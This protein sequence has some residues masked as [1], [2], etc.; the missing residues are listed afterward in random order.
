MNI[1]KEQTGAQTATLRIEIGPDD[2]AAN[3]QK[4]LKDYQKKASIPGFRPG[5]VPTGLIKKMYGKAVVADEVNKLLTESLSGYIQ[6]EKLNILGNP[7]PNKEKTQP[8]SFEDGETMEFFFDLGFAPE[9][10]LKLDGTIEVDDYSII[11]EESMLD[12]YI[13]ETRR[14]FGDYTHPDLPEEGDMVSGEAVETD[15]AGQ[16]VEAGIKK[17]VFFYLD[18]VKEEKAKSTLLGMKKDETITFN[19]IGF[20][21]S[22]DEA[23]AHLGL[24]KEQVETPGL[25]LTFTMQDVVRLIPAELNSEF[26]A[27]VY[28][29]QNLET[30]D[31]F[32]AQVRKD[33]SSGFTGE[34]D[35]ILFN[36]ITEAL[37]KNTP[38]TLPDDFLKRWL[39]DNDERPYSDEEIEQ[40][41]PAFADSM[42]WQLIE[43][44]VIRENDIRVTDED[45]RGYIRTVLLRQVDA[46]PADPEKEKRYDSIIDAFMQN[47]EQVQRIND[48]LYSARLLDLFKKSLVLKTKEVGY[49]EFVKLV[50]E[51]H[52][53]DHEHDHDHDHHG[54]DHGHDHDHDH[55]HSH[56]H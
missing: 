54:H 45:I 21:G 13:E 36:N 28:P 51:K 48:Q 8:I 3:V 6:D 49:E 43:N 32:R 42:R 55:D 22:A 19:P 1:T 52:A 23:V 29:G 53:H 2:Y 12:K 24:K 31:D 26:Y 44:K 5:H 14:R 17:N 39:R 46:G 10:E 37:V 41:Y 30:Y 27:K 35:K 4:V 15:P 56:S 7:M 33:A 25:V 20:L 11:V 50:S 34:T 40:Q 16:P 38:I 9:F 18:K 47:K